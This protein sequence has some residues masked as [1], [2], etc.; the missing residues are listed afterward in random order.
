MKAHLLIDP[1]RGMT[2]GSFLAALL[3]VG[4]PCDEIFGAMER[5]GRL[6]GDLVSV[7]EAEFAPEGGVVHLKLDLHQNAVPQVSADQVHRCLA[8]ALAEVGVGDPY[9]SVAMRALAALVEAESGRRSD[10]LLTPIGMAHTPYPDRSAAPS[11]PR[12]GAPGPFYVDLYPEFREGLRGLEKRSHIF[13]LAYL[14]RAAG[15]DLTV[16]PP[17]RRPDGPPLGLFSSRSPNRPSP[18]GLTLTELRAVEGPRIHTG[19]LD[20]VD[21][22]P[23]V[24]IKPYAPGLDDAPGRTSGGDVAVTRG[25]GLAP[26][27][28]APRGIC[29]TL[30]VLVGIAV[31]LARMGIVLDDLLCL[32]PVAVESRGAGPATRTILAAEHIPHISAASAVEALLSP[33]GAALLAALA[34]RF[35][36][37][38]IPLPGEVTHLGTGIESHPGTPQAPL[39]LGIWSPA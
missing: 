19:P 12:D 4:A 17:H 38:E 8:R 16:V 13:I 39:R 1:V 2:A 23:V 15:Y 29:R 27:R 32:S 34:P 30:V 25:G 18:L 37:R 21:G 6:M 36:P 3:G 28:P 11:Q 35:F 22:T 24:D 5:A 10:L 33:D 31:G 20:F 14:D 26:E 7:M 9:D